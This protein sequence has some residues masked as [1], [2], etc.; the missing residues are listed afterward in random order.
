MFLCHDFLVT[1][2]D[3]FESFEVK[4]ELR[5]LLGQRTSAS[6]H[7]LAPGSIRGPDR[8]NSELLF[9]RPHVMKP[10]KEGA[11]ER[12]WCGAENILDIDIY[13]HIY[14]YNTLL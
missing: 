4:K 6:S 9:P 11:S 14:I 3:T 10:K 2:S 12:S 7:L 5:W 8:L 1:V 13:V